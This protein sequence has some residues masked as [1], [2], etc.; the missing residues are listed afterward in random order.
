MSSNINV[1]LE[2]PYGQVAIPRAKLHSS[3]DSTVIANPM[4]ITS[5]ENPYQVSSSAPPPYTVKEDGGGM[6]KGG[7]AV[8]AATVA[9]ERS[10]IIAANRDT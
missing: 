3:S 10:D 2:N 1:S 5:N 6:M 9:G 4:V 7:A 8:P